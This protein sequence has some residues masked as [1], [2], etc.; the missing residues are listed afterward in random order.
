M[1]HTFNNENGELVPLGEWRY[2]GFT[3]IPIPR[4]TAAHLMIRIKTLADDAPEWRKSVDVYLRNSGR[5]SLVGIEREIG[6][7]GLDPPS[8]AEMATEELDK[9][10][11]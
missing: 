9:S 3:R 8:L 10:R 5:P 6:I 11:N 7:P 1:W 4:N 2:T